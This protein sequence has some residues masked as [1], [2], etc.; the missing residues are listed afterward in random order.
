M[1]STIPDP[2]PTP[3]NPL[4]VPLKKYDDMTTEERFE[5]DRLQRQREIAEQSGV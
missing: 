1:S 5:Y 2:V 4:D 3:V